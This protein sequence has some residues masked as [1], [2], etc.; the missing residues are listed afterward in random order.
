MSKL[1]KQDHQYDFQITMNN[2][3]NSVLLD[4]DNVKEISAIANAFKVNEKN[5]DRKKK[6][7]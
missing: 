5:K 4:F 3:F 1:F 2:Y 6:R 7:T